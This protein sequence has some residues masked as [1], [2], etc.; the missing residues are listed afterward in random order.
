MTLE[1]IAAT[2]RNSMASIASTLTLVPILENGSSADPVPLEGSVSEVISATV[3]LY[4]RRGFQPPWIG[5]LAVEGNRCVGS[6]GFAHPPKDGEVEIAY[7]TFPGNEGHGV[8]TRMARELLNRTR[9]AARSAK[10]DFIA[11]TLPHESPSA[12]ILR[13]LGFRLAGE[14]QHPDDGRVWKWTS[15]AEHAGTH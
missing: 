5:Y 12:S 10:V 4:A 7:F 6:C 15:V 9:A 1:V 13:K 11:H 14:I 8:A 2:P 3:Q